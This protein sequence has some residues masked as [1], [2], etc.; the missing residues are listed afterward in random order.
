MTN[1]VSIAQSGS[2]NVTMRN[3]IINGSMVID[4]RNNGT[5]VSAS[6]TG[7]LT[8]TLDRWAYVVSQASKL[9]IQQH[10]G[11][12]TPPP[13]FTKYLGA[14]VGASA[15]V[16]VGAGDYFFL[17]QNI[18]GYNIAD[19]NFGTANAQPI[20]VSFWVRA[21]VTGNFG[22]SL[23]T[24]NPLGT[25]RSYTTTYTINSANTWEYKTIT[26]A[27][28]TGGSAVWQTNNAIGIRI[29]FV[30]G[31]GSTYTQAAGSW[32]SD[33]VVSTPTAVSLITTNSATFYVTG[34]Q[35]EKGSTATPFEQRLYGTELALCQ[36]YYQQLP[37]LRDGTTLVLSNF[38]PG[39][40]ERI[41]MPVLPVQ[42]RA[43]PTVV[44]YRVAGTNPGEI[45]EF[46]A[47]T[48]RVVSSYQARDACGGGYLQCATSFANPAQ[49]NLTYSAEL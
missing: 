38:A 34:V 20:T 3:R 46:S 22:F 16:T 27:G 7:A 47:G 32:T 31:A 35:L 12:V 24:Y 26:I 2:N 6:A 41:P 10:A 17:Q 29:N 25:F 28:D 49:L 18:E 9:T 4:Q 33:N 13:G 23:S 45:T 48:N 8:Y 44:S 1:A 30:L 14:T 5:S 37:S 39:S 11:A 19:F 42:M 21:S 43:I 15:N 36:R 40:P